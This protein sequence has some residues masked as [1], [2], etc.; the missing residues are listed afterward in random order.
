M[1]TLRPVLALAF[2]TALHAADAAGGSALPTRPGALGHAGQETR[3][4]PVPLTRDQFVAAVTREL[5]AHFNLDGELQ[6][7]L[8]RPWTPP[9]RVA[10]VWSASVGEFPAVPSASMLVRC[11][12]QA[13]HVL[14]ADSPLIVRAAHWRDV[15]VTRAPLTAGAVFDPAQ[16]E[17]RRTDLFRERDVVPASV[18]DRSYVFA[19]A[20]PAGRVLTWHDI[21]RRPLVKKGDVVEVSASE[22]RLVVTMKALAMENG[23][24][25]DTVTVR[26]PE[27]HRNFTAIVVNEN[28]VQVRF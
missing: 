19:R 13:D 28:R 11:R 7:E 10:C 14:V 17:T 26:N 24:Q 22:G 18:G 16:L 20:I 15:W 8:L 21:A 1:R 3:A 12:I 25:G 23:A 5:A 6:L 4:T 9:D 27:S 2:A